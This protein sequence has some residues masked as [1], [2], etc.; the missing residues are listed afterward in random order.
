M[1]VTKEFPTAFTPIKGDVTPCFQDIIESFLCSVGSVKAFFRPIAAG[2]QWV[3]HVFFL[4]TTLRCAGA[5][6]HHTRGIYMLSCVNAYKH[7]P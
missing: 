7:K 5:F 2:M 6:R 4:L 3:D 1:C